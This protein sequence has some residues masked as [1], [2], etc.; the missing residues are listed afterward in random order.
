[1]DTML[2]PQ[3]MDSAYLAVSTWLL[4][5]V[6]VPSTAVQAMVAIVCL[7]VARILTSRL[8][9]RIESWS[10]RE[11]TSRPV[12]AGLQALARHSLPIIW[13]VLQWVSVIVANA[14]GWPAHLVTIVASR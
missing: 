14:A 2:D 10:L 5:N 13:L 4:D 12:K 7:V 11:G 1:M 3:V 8:R 9:A 6:L